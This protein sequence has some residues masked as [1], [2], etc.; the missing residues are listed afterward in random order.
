MVKLLTVLNSMKPNTARVYIPTSART[1]CTCSLLSCLDEVYELSFLYTENVD[2]VPFWFKQVFQKD[3]GDLHLNFN[4][5][6]F[7]KSHSQSPL[8]LDL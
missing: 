7:E 8:S 2:M 5:I 6:S 1:T 3:T 4:F